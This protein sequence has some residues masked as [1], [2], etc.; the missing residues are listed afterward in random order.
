VLGTDD[1]HIYLILDDG[2]TATGFPFVTGDKI[3]TAPSILEINSEKTI[4]AGS[5]DDYLYAVN[6]DGSL[7][8]SFMSENKIQ[9]SPSFLEIN[10]EAAIFFGNNDGYIHSLNMNGTPLPGWPVVMNG[11]IEGSVVFSDLDGD[12]EAEIV[13]ASNTGELGA[14]FLDGSTYPYFPI[15]NGSPYKGSVLIIDLDNDD[16]LEIMGGSVNNL[17]VIDVKENGSSAN[18]WHIFR[19]NNLRNGFAILGDSECEA[20]LGD[21]NGDNEINILDLV[22]VA[23]LILEVSIPDFECVADFTQDGEVNILDLVQIVNYILES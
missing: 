13:A 11:D 20:D 3:Q 1:N 17:E 18:Y 9:A 12:G 8:F 15:L 16:D 23:N 21:V 19:G 10:G 7:Q 6:S 14:F 22:Q 5:N 4:F 2:S